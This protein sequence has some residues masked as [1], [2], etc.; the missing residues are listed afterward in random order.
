MKVRIAPEEL[1]AVPGLE[2]VDGLAS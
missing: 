1:R 2:I